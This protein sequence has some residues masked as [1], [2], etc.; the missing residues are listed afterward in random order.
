[1]I[2]H[3]I[4]N[5]LILAISSVYCVSFLIPSTVIIIEIKIIWFVFDM[6]SKSV[7]CCL[8]IIMHELFVVVKHY[9]YC[10]VF[11]SYFIYST[12]NSSRIKSI[13]SVC[14]QYL[15]KFTVW[16]KLS[17]LFSWIN[18][19]VN[20]EWLINMYFISSPGSWIPDNEQ[21]KKWKKG[22]RMIF[23]FGFWPLITNSHFEI[24]NKR[25]ACILARVLNK[26]QPQIAITF[27]NNNNRIV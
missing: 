20:I 6:H 24:I 4:V 8:F 10:I 25:I 27:W 7:L 22:I 18:R 16:E 15:Y 12:V 2:R 14:I 23:W 21:K 26:K 1:M 3:F 9:Y 13:Y 11:W 19:L 17:C 5:D